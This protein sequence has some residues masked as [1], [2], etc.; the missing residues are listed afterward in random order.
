MHIVKQIGKHDSSLEF[1]GDQ[2]NIQPL[3][4]VFASYL[5]NYS[6]DDDQKG[7]IFVSMKLHLERLLNS[8][9]FSDFSED[10]V[11]TDA[12]YWYAVYHSVLN[13]KDIIDHHLHMELRQMS[14]KC[15]EIRN[16]RDYWKSKYEQS[17]NKV[18]ELE[19]NIP[20]GF[21]FPKF[22]DNS[23]MTPGSFAYVPN[24]ES[25][26]NIKIEEL[27]FTENSVYVRD[28]SNNDYPVESVE[29]PKPD[30]KE[31]ILKELAP[32]LDDCMINEYLERLNKVDNYADSKSID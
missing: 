6:L 26:S 10:E 13:A 28:S 15:D 8:N 19:S 18:K 7:E 11:Q 1:L 2:A 9:D 4:E 12:E 30:T 22:S 31:S 20:E 3:C 17:N 23:F 25:G 14:Q 29:A 32:E 27:V 16:S 21:R 5:D 24:D